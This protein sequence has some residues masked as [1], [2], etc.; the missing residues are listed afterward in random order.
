MSETTKRNE[1]FFKKLLC[2]VNRKKSREALIKKASSDNIDAL[3]E[4]AL[5]VLKGNLELSKTEKKKLQRHKKKLRV[6][7]RRNI[8]V[9]RKKSFLVQEGGFLPLM[10]TPF[11]SAAGYIAGRAISSA[12]DL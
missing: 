6:L 9:K 10:L 1:A 12:L 5:N 4:V 7:G 8:S 3:S 11:L 2:G